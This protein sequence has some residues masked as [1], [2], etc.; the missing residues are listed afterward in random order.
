M[1]DKTVLIIAYYFPPM[2]LSGVQRTLKFAK[3]LPEYGWKPMVLTSHISPYYAFDDSLEKEI[4][5]L[6]IPVFRTTSKRNPKQKQI[7]FP[8]TFVQKTARYFTSAIYQ[9]DRFISWKARAVRKGERIFAK[10][11]I[12]AIFATAPPFTDFLVAKELSEKFDVPFIVDYRDVWIDNP[13]HYFPTKF[14]KNYC[15]KLENEILNKARKIIV[16]SRTTKELLIKRYGIVSYDDIVIVPHGYDTDDF[17][18]FKE[19]SPNVAKFTITH[20]GLFQDNRTPKYFLKA[21]SEFITKYKIEPG[22]LEARFV[23]IMRK[24]HLKLIGKYNLQGYVNITGFQNHNDVIRNLMQSD[25]LWMYLDDTVRSPGKLYEYI[26]ARKPLLLCVSDG[27]M[28][29]TALDT[30]AAI[31]T[32][33]KDTNM[34]MKAIETYYQLWLEKKLPQ[35]DESFAGRFDRKILTGNLAK[36][37]TL[38][39]E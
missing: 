27:E 11:K 33:P 38:V 9:P 13:F 35:P 18:P 15:I 7:K 31:A 10:N 22:S 24:N 30:K 14:H 29:R 16:T 17:E 20:S 34:I 2:G 3:F 26:G 19:V 12:D 37:L 1:Q 25:V 39:T 36:E 23:G 6:E 21:L 8:S 5:D 28:R 32:N 4:E